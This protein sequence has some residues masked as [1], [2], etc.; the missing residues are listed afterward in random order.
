[1]EVNI[2]TNNFEPRR[3]C[4]RSLSNG[5][6]EMEV[7]VSNSTQN[8]F[9]KR[10]K[11]G[12]KTF[13]ET[14]DDMRKIP[15]PAHRYS[16]LKENWLKIFSPIVEHLQLHIRF[17]LKTRNVEIKTSEHTKDIGNLQK[18]ADF[19][20]VRKFRYLLKVNCVFFLF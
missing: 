1:M 14:K 9:T 3:V 8:N 12:T 11:L 5:D 19:V 10:K 7:D 13:S 15:V 18:A 17:N 16:P 6:D 2:D 20:K 4:K